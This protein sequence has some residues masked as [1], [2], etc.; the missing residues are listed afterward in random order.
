VTPNHHN[1]L[2]IKSYLNNL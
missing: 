1:P 2:L